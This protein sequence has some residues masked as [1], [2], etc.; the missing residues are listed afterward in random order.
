MILFDENRLANCHLPAGNLALLVLIA[1]SEQLCIQVLEIPY[2]WN[3]HTVIPPEISSLSFD[4]PFLMGV[5]ESTVAKQGFE[6]P[7]GTK[8]NK[9]R[10]FFSAISLQDL[11]HCRFQIVIAQA[12]EDAAKSREGLLVR[13]EK[14]L[15]GRPQIRPMKRTT[16]GH[17]AHLKNLEAGELSPKVCMRLIPVYLSL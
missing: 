14:R 5:L 10:R 11:F 2:M 15:L 7:V 3:G 16:T 12:L 9:S 6:V 1:C 17:A 4:A 13:F 8:G